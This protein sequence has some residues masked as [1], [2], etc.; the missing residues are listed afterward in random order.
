MGKI[1]YKTVIFF[2]KMGAY[3]TTAAAKEVMKA[4]KNGLTVWVN[5]PLRD[6]KGRNKKAPCYFTDDLLDVPYMEDGLF[7]Y[8]EAY[9][10]LNS[11]K[12]RELNEKIHVA[13]M[14]IRKRHMNVV[15]IAQ[16]W[17]RIDSSIRE[18]AEFARLFEG[19]SYFGYRV[20]FQDFPINEEGE[21]VKPTDVRVEPATEGNY[22]HP[23]A[24]FPVFNT[25]FM[26]DQVGK[27][28]WPNAIDYVIPAEM[29][30]N[31]RT[32]SQDISGVNRSD[33]R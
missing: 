32:F 4:N 21:I 28:E 20:H 6:W 27:K 10:G 7:V 31:L 15:V 9:R 22:W 11:R 25:D 29:L 16:S 3:K 17:K 5:F 30:E 33:N 14:H 2:G 1:A 19:S 26:F 13:F 8:D 12:W 24:A 18:V 23:Q